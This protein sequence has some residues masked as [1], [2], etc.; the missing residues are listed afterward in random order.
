[1]QRWCRTFRQREGRD[2]SKFEIAS[3]LEAIGWPMP[4]PS[5]PH[6]LLANQVARAEAEEVVHDQVLGD[7]VGRNICYTVEVA[8]K[9]TTLWGELDTA[10]RKKMDTHKTILRDQSVGDVYEAT[11]KC[12][13]WNRLHPGEQPVLFDSDFGPDME[14]KL[15]APKGKK[16]AA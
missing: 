4:K 15:N 8:G 14:W 16:D 11:K 9:Q 6:E 13:R 10:T 1:M 3:M 12:M 2:L 7:S 5:T